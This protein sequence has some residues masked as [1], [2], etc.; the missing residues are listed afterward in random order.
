MIQVFVFNVLFHFDMFVIFFRSF[1][2][3]IFF[4]LIQPVGL[5]F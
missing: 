3:Y 2:Y 5:G 1:F 4:F